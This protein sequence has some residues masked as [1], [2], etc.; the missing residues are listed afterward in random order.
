MRALEMLNYL[1]CLNDDGDLADIGDQAAEFPLD[2]QLAK[3]LIDSPNHKCSNEI[4]S[5]AAMLSVP[6]VF[7]RPKEF[8]KEADEAKGRFAHLDGDHLTLL[9][10]FHAYKQY[11][12]EGADPAQ[13]CYDNYINARS[14]KSAESVREQ[15]KRT[16]ERLNLP[17]VSTD[18][19]D[20]EYYP[21]I[22]RCLVAGFFMQVAHL[23]KSG[24]YLTVK[25]NQVV[26]LHPS[27]CISHKP[28]WVLYNEFVLTSK[29]F[30]RTV[31]QVRGE[32]LIEL[33]PLYYD[34]KNFPKSEAR[35]QLERL[36]N[37]RHTTQHQ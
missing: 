34:V 20:K 22:R 18:F 3:M 12:T 27:T 13:F 19:R 29:N 36:Q 10:V 28:E 7:V 2:P 1:G 9:N 31:I 37:Q 30:I 6:M 25:D 23:E 21:N 4:L 8:A 35:S 14:M 33:A 17:M 16:M 32:W 24:H 26:A 15:L 11:T 5:I